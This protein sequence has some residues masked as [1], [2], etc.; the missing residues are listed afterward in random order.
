[1]KKKSAKKCISFFMVLLLCASFLP[2]CVFAAEIGQDTEQTDI[3][4]MTQEEEQLPDEKTVPAVQEEQLVDNTVTT[5]VQ[6]S[7]QLSSQ[8]TSPMPVLKKS[9]WYNP[10]D[11]EYTYAWEDK[12]FFKYATVWTNIKHGTYLPVI[13][14]EYQNQQITWTSSDE[15]VAYVDENGAVHLKQP[16]GA[17]ITAT[18]P[19]QVYGTFMLHIYQIVVKNPSIE[20]NVD[21]TDQVLAYVEAEEP[22]N[23]SL[24]LTYKLNESSAKDVVTVDENGKLY[25]I[26]AGEAK[27]DV[28]VQGTEKTETVNVKVSDPEAAP[29]AGGDS[30][31]ET[32]DQSGGG[33]E[34]GTGDQ[35]GD[36]SEGGTDDQS[37][38]GSEG[39]TDD[40]SGSGSE[41]GT[42]SQPG[43]ESESG[44]VVPG[45]M[46]PVRAAMVRIRSL[47]IRQIQV[48][49]L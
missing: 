5:N 30:E 28:G 9:A 19:N 29:P 13:S 18:L 26:G 21:D 27:I 1:M 40:Q 32:D 36:G 42:D 20:M 17:K 41:D 37:G 2:T 3:Q 4:I 44:T 23:V 15:S 7:T 47:G 14:E 43:D 35:P 25:A 22:R 6:S 49:L 11:T 24:I 8:E 48:L 46:L 33:S 12:G 34:G 38:G 16:K 45:V 39:G 31:G 10:F